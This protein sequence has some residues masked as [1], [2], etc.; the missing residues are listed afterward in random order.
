MTVEERLKL[1]I[2]EAN[3][4]LAIIATRLEEAQN[5]IEILEAALNKKQLNENEN[6]GDGKWKPEPSHVA[7]ENGA[8]QS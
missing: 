6:K 5:K 8:R 4:Q 2:G 3:F 7:M 1:M